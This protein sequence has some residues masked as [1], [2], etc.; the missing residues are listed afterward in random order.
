L[1]V[2]V[3]ARCAEYLQVEMDVRYRSPLIA[4]NPSKYTLADGNLRMFN[5]LSELIFSRTGGYLMLAAG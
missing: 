1:C 5:V 2:P 4:G 3:R